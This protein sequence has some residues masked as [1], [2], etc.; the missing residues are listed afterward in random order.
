MHAR[1]D[2]VGVRELILVSF[3]DLHVLIR[4]AIELLADFGKAVAC[5]NHIR[6]G[7][8]S[9]G[10]TR[11]GRGRC[12]RGSLNVGGQVGKSLGQPV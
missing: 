1:L 7:S 8:R 3:K 9:G 5:L 6:T 4:V 2:F 11:A 10:R 12:S